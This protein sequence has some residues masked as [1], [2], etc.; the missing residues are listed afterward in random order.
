MI[1]RA[2]K[3]LQA[4]LKR[5]KK[6]MMIIFACLNAENILHL[7]YEFMCAA[8]ERTIFHVK[9]NVEIL[10][11]EIKEIH[12]TNHDMGNYINMCHK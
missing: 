1:L 8:H 12:P 9:Y 7:T 11:S 10:D 4:R 2:R 6:H 5:N 3:I